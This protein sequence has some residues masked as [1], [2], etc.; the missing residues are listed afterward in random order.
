MTRVVNLAC[1]R[2][3]V[4]HAVA[5]DGGGLSRADAAGLGAGL[6]GMRERVASLDGVLD[7]ESTPGAGT[8][9]T[10]EIPVA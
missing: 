4:V 6:I 10:V 8:R 9:L 5:D 7:I 2:R 3:S 1:R